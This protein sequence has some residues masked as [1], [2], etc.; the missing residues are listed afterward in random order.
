MRLQEVPEKRE[1][2]QEKERGKKFVQFR[3]IT[4]NN[5]RIP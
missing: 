3:Q 2:R 4:A 1:T 5:W